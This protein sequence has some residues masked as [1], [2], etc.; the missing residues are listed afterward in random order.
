LKKIC[1][2]LFCSKMRTKM[3]KK[4]IF[5]NILP[6]YLFIKFHFFTFAIIYYIF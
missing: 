3:A 4:N 6:D 1:F 5:L 2:A